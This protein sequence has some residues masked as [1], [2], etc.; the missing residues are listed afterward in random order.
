MIRML[1]KYKDRT[2]KEFALDRIDSLSIGRN[3]NHHLVIDNFAVSGNHA[4]INKEGNRFI[5]KDTHSKNGTFLNGL[6]VQQAILKNGDLITIGKHTLVFLDHGRSRP[7]PEQGGLKT[8]GLPGDPGPDHTMFMDTEVYRRMLTE[9]GRRL[10][11]VHHG[12]RAA[13]QGQRH[14]RR[15]T[16]PRPRAIEG[17]SGHG[18]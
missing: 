12:G 3:P 2:I 18:A 9:M 17:R 14:D 15:G 4:V 13:G 5:L 7:R 10:V 16:G 1:V 6:T 11:D 8:S